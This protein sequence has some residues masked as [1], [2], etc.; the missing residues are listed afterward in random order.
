MHFEGDESYKNVFSSTKFGMNP[1]ASWWFQPIWKILV[2]LIISPNRDEH[3][4]MFETTTQ[5]RN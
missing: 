3:K 5:N 1:M 2:K 4:N